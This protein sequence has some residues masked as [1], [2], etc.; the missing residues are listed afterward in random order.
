MKDVILL[1]D[2]LPSRYSSWL[3][4]YVDVKKFLEEMGHEFDENTEIN[5]FEMGMLDDECMYKN[6]TGEVTFSRQSWPL[7]LIKARALDH[8]ISKI[9]SYYIVNK[10]R[11]R[12]FTVSQYDDFLEGPFNDLLDIFYPF[13]EMI[14]LLKNNFTK[15]AP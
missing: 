15:V 2:Y 14:D 8:I 10:M 1:P 9:P 13:K 4:L 11:E 12:A 3:H 6:G 7:M 5:L